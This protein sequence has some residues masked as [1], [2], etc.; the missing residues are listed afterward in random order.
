MNHDHRCV[1]LTQ[2]KL[3]G[4][5]LGSKTYVALLNLQDWMEVEAKLKE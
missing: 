2:L 1:T 5:S 3:F 4:I